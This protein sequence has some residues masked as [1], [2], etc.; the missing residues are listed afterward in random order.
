MAARRSFPR[1]VSALAAFGLVVGGA[2]AALPASADAWVEQPADVV[3]SPALSLPLRADGQRL[4]DADGRDV[5]LRGISVGNKAAPFLPD[6]DAGDLERIRGLGLNHLRLYI[7]WEGVMPAEGQV[8]QGYLDRL[9]ELVR[10][11]DQA[12]LLVIVDTHQDLYGGPVGNG[13]PDWAYRPGACPHISFSSVSG[14][15]AADYL[16]PAVACAFSRFWRSGELQRHY[17]DAWVAVAA[18]VGG[19]PNVVGYDLINEPFSGQIPPVFFERRFLFP[20]QAAWLQAIRTVDPDAVGFLE[21]S[22]TKNV[23]ATE[24]PP[25]GL[26]PP[27][28][29][30][31]P[32]LYGPWDATSQVPLLE[33][34][35]V[36][37]EPNFRSSREAARRA[38]VPLWLGEWGVF[39]SATG[40]A[41]YASSVYDLVDDA[42][43]ST[44]IWEYG[45]PAYGPFGADGR[46]TPI[47]DAVRRPYPEAV[48]GTLTGIDYER[49]TR[50]LRISSWSD[51]GGS[52]RLR[53]PAGLYPTG[54]VVEGSPRW[55]WDR[56]A[57][58]LVTDLEPGISSMSVSPR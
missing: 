22:F 39:T 14:A 12:G 53:V 46:P 35:R 2:F 48:P 23:F 21:P 6:L 8:D 20:R 29:V 28:S 26:M 5:I 32:H 51:A 9:H 58:V 16:S 13:A 17:T 36:L 18:A 3:A 44:A 41:D 47:H 45:D 33:Q 40:A 55:H 15:W 54:I 50:V 10:L 37:T 19:E 52:A 43:A 42:L 31:A 57:G 7:S 49:D 56:D 24:L 25:V 30:Y 4:R 34:T 11:A 1:R 38:G 27:N